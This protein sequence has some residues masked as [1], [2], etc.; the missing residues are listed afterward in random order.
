M[1]LH[2][3]VL[4]AFECSK[5]V[6]KKLYYQEFNLSS[7]L[8]VHTN[9]NN[10]VSHF[11]P[12][13]PQCTTKKHYSNPFQIS[14][15]APLVERLTVRQFNQFRRNLPPAGAGLHQ[16]G[17]PNCRSSFIPDLNKPWQPTNCLA[18]IKLPG[19]RIVT[20]HAFCLNGGAG[21]RIWLMV[22]HETGE[23]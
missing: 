19:F 4:Y 5:L 22:S 1:L 10:I 6:E 8:P 9:S 7:Q 13:P 15:C 16:V 20:S 11:M 12:S 23:V 17:N 14:Y 2:N 18:H 21:E 3:N